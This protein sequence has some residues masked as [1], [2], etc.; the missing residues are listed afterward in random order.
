MKVFTYANLI[1]INKK[2]SA[3][4]YGNECALLTLY[5]VCGVYCPSEE[6]TVQKGGVYC[7]NLA[8]LG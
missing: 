1:S 8:I 3:L 2:E 7:P 5:M 4:E 6:S